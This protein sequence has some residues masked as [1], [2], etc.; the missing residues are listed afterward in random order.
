[1]IGGSTQKVTWLFKLWSHEAMQQI[2]NYIYLIPQLHKGQT[3]WGD[4]L[5]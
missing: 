4:D 2:E 1:M 5:P 3:W